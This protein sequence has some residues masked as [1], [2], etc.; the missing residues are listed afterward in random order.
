[1][2]EY[3]HALNRAADLYREIQQLVT[4]QNN[5]Y[6]LNVMTRLTTCTINFKSLIEQTGSG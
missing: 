3:E 6:S 4:T 1:M 5:D 2:A